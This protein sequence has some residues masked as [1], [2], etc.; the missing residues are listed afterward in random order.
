[1]A[2]VAV[3]LLLVSPCMSQSVAPIA[4]NSPESCA[5]MDY[6]NIGNL[7]CSNCP[8][9]FTRSNLGNPSLGCSCVIGHYKSLDQVSQPAA[10][11]QCPDQDSIVSNDGHFCLKCQLPLTYNEG[12]CVGCNSTSVFGMLL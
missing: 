4:Y 5:V 11:H 8:V 3:I 9:N 6:Y 2:I 12:A 7:S 10:C 1:M